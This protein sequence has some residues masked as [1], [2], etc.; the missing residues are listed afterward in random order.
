MKKI[1]IERFITIALASTLA[2]SSLVVF[3]QNKVNELNEMK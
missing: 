1:W 2:I 3:G